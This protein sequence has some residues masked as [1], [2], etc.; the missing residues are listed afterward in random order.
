MQDL[1]VSLAVQVPLVAAFMWF[2]LEMLKRFDAA[3]ARRDEA[4]AN[5]AERLGQLHLAMQVHDEKLERVEQ[6]V[7]QVLARQG[8]GAD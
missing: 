5:V 8:R 7:G 3:L 2:A 4:L 1:W 6:K